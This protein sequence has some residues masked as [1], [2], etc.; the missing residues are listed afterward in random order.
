MAPGL[1]RV[2][3]VMTPFMAPGGDARARRDNVQYGAVFDQGRINAPPTVV[4]PRDKPRDG[5]VFDQ[6]RINAPPVAAF[7]P[8]GAPFMAPGLTRVRDVM[9]PSATFLLLISALMLD[10]RRALTHNALCCY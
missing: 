5:A 10:A 9:T 7:F 3:N 1:M 2:R 6:G 4:Y 8:A